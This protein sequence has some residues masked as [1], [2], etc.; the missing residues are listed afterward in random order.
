MLQKQ[1][2]NIIKLN[3]IIFKANLIVLQ[4]LRS[5]TVWAPAPGLRSSVQHQWKS[6]LST[7]RWAD[8]H[9]PRGR[10]TSL[11]CLPNCAAFSEWSQGQKM[12]SA[13]QSCPT[14]RNPMYC[15]PPGSSVHGISQT[16]RLEWVAISSSRASSW[17]RDRTCIF[18]LVYYGA[19]WEAQ[20]P[21]TGLG[22]MQSNKITRRQLQSMFYSLTNQNELG[23]L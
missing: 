14:L 13:A 16:R 18:C 17:L 1:T 15:S 23:I 7:S 2:V 6:T 21:R 9:H 12:C 3:F 4:L 11:T 5:S 8:R 20:D 10:L 19:T 22:Q